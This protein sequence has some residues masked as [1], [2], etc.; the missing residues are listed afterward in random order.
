MD[1][2]QL[3]YFVTVADKKNYSLAAKELYVTQPTLSLAIQKLE[4]EFET[5]LFKQS[6]RQLILTESGRVLYESGKELLKNYNKVVEKMNDFHNSNQ[7]VLKVGLTV[8]F[9]IQYMDEISNFIA[10]QPKVELRLIQ[11]GSKKLQHMVVNDELDIGLLSFPQYENSIIMEKIE[12]KKGSYK[13]AVVLPKNHHLSE[14]SSLS[15]A[16]FKNQKLSSLSKSYVLGNE[17]YIKCREYGFDPNIVF[18]DDNWTVLVKSVLT[19]NSMVLLPAEF[20]EIGKFSDV[21]WIPLEE[22]I[23]YFIGVAHRK[24][25]EISE[26]AELFIESILK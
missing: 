21:K 2:R 23:E 10:T 25:K 17:I 20:E 18:T 6:N 8:L 14:R 15:I 7:T 3:N 5:V 13:A 1:I 26:M 19:F 9:A 12:K 16:D 24:D 22:D 4:K 11:H